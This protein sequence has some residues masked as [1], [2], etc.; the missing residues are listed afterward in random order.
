MHNELYGKLSSAL[1]ERGYTFYYKCL[2]T[3]QLTP[4]RH[5]LES[6]GG[7]FNALEEG[8]RSMVAQVRLA[9]QN[10]EEARPYWNRL[11]KENGCTAERQVVARILN[12]L[13]TNDS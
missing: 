3:C 6:L 11:G 13:I 5:L 10:S 2:W 7:R 12:I 4:T 9:Y 8:S 1:G